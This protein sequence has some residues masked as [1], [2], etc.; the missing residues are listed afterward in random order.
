MLSM[1]KKRFSFDPDIRFS[2]AG[3]PWS[4]L[5]WGRYKLANNDKFKMNI[6]THLGLNYIT[7]VLPINGD[8]SA[9]TVTRRYLAGEIFPRYLL[10]KNISIGIYCLYSHG[11]DAGT[12]RNTNFITLNSNFSNIK[13]SKRFFLN[14]N[15]QCYYLRLDEHDGFYF[16]S[17]VTL[18][19]KDFP[20]SFSAII[21]KAI[22]TDIVGDD[23]VWNLSL[24]YAFQKKYV[25][26]M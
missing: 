24:V 2:L 13:L 7:S 6:G 17:T 8:T 20:I 3:K 15:P 4:F 1:V 11:L 9:T 19:K 16:T 22:E 12:I 14:I 21:N 26:R 23:L 10:T 18:A 5:F 25:E